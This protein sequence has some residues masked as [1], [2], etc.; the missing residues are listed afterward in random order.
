MTK[1]IMN[2]PKS[3]KNMK[4]ELSATDRHTDK[5]AYRDAKTHL[6]TLMEKALVKYNDQLYKTVV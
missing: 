2:S 4:T 1:A 3:L 6:K 5:P